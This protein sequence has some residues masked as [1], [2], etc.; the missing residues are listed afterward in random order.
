MSRSVMIGLGVVGLLALVGTAFA[1]TRFSDVDETHVQYR[2][3]EYAAEQGW[4]AGYEDG[5]FKPDRAIPSHQLTTVIGRAFPEG[6]TRADLATFLRGGAER[7][8]AL[9]SQSS[10]CESSATLADPASPGCPGVSG[11]WTFVI[12]GAER[13]PWSRWAD[14]AEGFIP[15]LVS[16]TA[17]Y[18]GTKDVGVTQIDTDF[19]MFITGISHDYAPLGCDTAG[20]GLGGAP[21]LLAGASTTFK[22]CFVVPEDRVGSGAYIRAYGDFYQPEEKR[23]WHSVAIP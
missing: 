15:I 21:D 9:P 17:R 1:A 19:T 2:D 11:S 13:S 5:T 7:L 16:V 3:I 8:A 12:H 4:F 23:T 10:N 20:E 18:D 22:I 6:A 14:Q